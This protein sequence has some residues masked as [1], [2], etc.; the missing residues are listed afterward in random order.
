M[1][2]GP[3]EGKP[4]TVDQI[5]SLRA[6]AYI[7]P[8]EGTRKVYLLE[9]ADEMNASAQNA[10]LKLL[11]EGPSYASFLLVA[12]DGGGVLQTIRSRCE[13]LMLSPVSQGEALDWLK[14]RCPSL[15]YETLEQAARDCQGILGRAAGP[16]GEQRP[17]SGAERTGRAAG[18]GPGDRGRAGA[19]PGR[20]G[21]GPRA[22][23]R[24]CAPCW[25]SWRPPWES[26]RSGAATAA[27]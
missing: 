4:I 10:M 17:R 6:D 25:M 23:G 18:P 16:A 19:F 15:P 12:S 20:H 13:Q 27:G 21:P 24:S 9:G 3:G 5:R 1:I 14:K 26:G 22:G 2:A 11:E 7:C 8:N